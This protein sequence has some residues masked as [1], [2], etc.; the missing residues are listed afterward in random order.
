MH[1]PAS[2]RRIMTASTVASRPPMKLSQT[3]TGS[4][5]KKD[6]NRN[7]YKGTP[8]PKDSSSGG[9]WFWTFMKF[10][11][12]GLTLTGAYVGFTVYRSKRRDRF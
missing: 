2:A 4:T 8:P 12:F 7:K 10:I 3:G 9:S 6:Y 5:A 11:I 1:L